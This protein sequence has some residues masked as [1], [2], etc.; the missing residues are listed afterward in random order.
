MLVVAWAWGWICLGQVA[1]AQASTGETLVVGTKE[2]PPY[3]YRDES[4]QWAGSSIALWRTLAEDLKL[5]YRFEE[6]DLGGLLEGLER[7]ELDAA[8]AAITVTSEREARFDFTH[9]FETSGLSVAVIERPVSLW[10]G[11]WLTL[12]SKSFV[13]L[14]VGLGLLQLVAG[15]AMWLFERRHPDRDFDTEPTRGIAGG[16]WWAVVTMTTVGYGDKTPRSAP[17]RVLALAWMGLSVVLISTFTATIAS[18]QTVERLHADISRPQDLVRL[19]VATVTN[20]T[21]AGW[22]EEHEMNYTAFPDAGAALEAL[23]AEEVEA[24]VYDRAL[25]EHALGQRE[26]HAAEDIALLPMTWLRQDYAIGVP[27][28]SPLRE[29]INAALPRIVR[30]LDA[31]NE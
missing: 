5:E 9:P 12:R 7:G 25:L 15:V 27:T 26:A 2:A 23:L 11:L 3:A 28:G 17:G 4:G 8:V 10:A 30:A 6:R 16:F 19:H 18:T 29:Q 31:D 1:S 24:F 20:S 21:S 22:L 14:L 13:Q